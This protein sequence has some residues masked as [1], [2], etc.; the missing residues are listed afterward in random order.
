M[1]V[2]NA[3]VGKLSKKRGERRSSKEVGLVFHSN[4]S[5]VQTRNVCKVQISILAIFLETLG[6]AA[7]SLSNPSD[8]L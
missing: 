4:S 1:E 7:S 6:G 3:F 5:W 2:V 8:L